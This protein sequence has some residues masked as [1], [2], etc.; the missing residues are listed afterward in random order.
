MAPFP[1]SKKI[2]QEEEGATKQ[3]LMLPCIPAGATEINN[4]VGVWREDDIWTYF[5]GGHPIY[6]HKA[7]DLRMFRVVTAQLIESGGCR[8]V[9]ILRTFG[10][11]KSSVIRS[12]NKLRHGG[13]EAFF[14]P[15]PVR[16]GGTKFTPQVLNQAQSLL[17][18]HY[19][20][21]EVANKLGLKYDTIRKAINDGRLKETQPQRATTTKSSRNTIDAK[22]AEGLGTA[23]TRTEERIGAAFGIGNGAISRFEPCLD[24]P[25]GGVLCGLPA[26]LANGLLH[27]AESL[28]CTRK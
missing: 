1:L 14:K 13:V 18:E 6:S 25:K 23:C 28:E 4:R 19:S 22:A 15:R 21:V 5:M 24:V 2:I 3:Q 7:D 26:L 16:Y 9:D 17:D 11:S 8:Q 10:V 20:R 27:G 12:V